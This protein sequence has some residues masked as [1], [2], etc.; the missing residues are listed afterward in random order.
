MSIVYEPE[1]LLLI[2]KIPVTTPAVLPESVFLRTD[3][4]LEA[5]ISRVMANGGSIQKHGTRQQSRESEAF[6]Y[7]RDPDGYSLELSTQAHELGALRL[8]LG[9]ELLEFEP[10]PVE[11]ELDGG[12][13]LP[14]AFG[15][16]G[17]EPVSFRG[18]NE[19][20]SGRE[21]LRRET[22]PREL[23]R[24]EERRRFDRDRVVGAAP[25]RRRALDFLDQR[26]E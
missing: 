1:K 15:R 17:C 3:A 5:L 16:V 8:A 4:D 21:R 13:H 25:L 7:V 11:L 23:A 24:D 18:D 9:A 12:A 22:E 2:A 19:L 20:A 26:L 14:I 6:A 10:A